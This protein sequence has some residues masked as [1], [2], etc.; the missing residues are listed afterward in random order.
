[1]PEVHCKALEN[2]HR[3]IQNKRYGMRTSGVV[4][5]DNVQLHM[6]IAAHT[7]TLLEHFICKL[8]DHSHCSHD[9]ALSNYHLF[10]CLKIWLKSQR[11]SCNELLKTSRWHTT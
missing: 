2:L 3:A 9:L 7:Q 4:L 1:M 6:S 5:H 11:F 8:F 10:T